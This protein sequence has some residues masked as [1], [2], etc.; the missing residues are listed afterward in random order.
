VRPTVD[1]QKLSNIALCRFAFMA[2]SDDEFWAS[3]YYNHPPLTD[4]ML[5]MAEAQLAVKLPGEY[6]RLLR[7]QNGGYTQGFGFPMSQPTTWAID[8]VPLY[9]LFGIVTDAS[10]QTAQNALESDYMIK[11]WGLPPRQVLLSGDGHWWITLDYRRGAVPS[12]AW[13]DVECGEDVQIAQT[14]ALFLDG[15]VPDSQFCGHDEEK[16]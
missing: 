10:I 8:H 7:L 9:E 16:V 12:V 13:I 15:L 3:N 5:T 1:S 2:I 6:V 14:F 11:E 4:E